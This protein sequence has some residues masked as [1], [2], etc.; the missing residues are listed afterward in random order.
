M[1]RHLRSTKTMAHTEFVSQWNERDLPD[2]QKQAE[3]D[4]HRAKIEDAKKAVDQ[5]IAETGKKESELS[6]EQLKP[7]KEARKKIEEL[8]KA[9]PQLPKVMAVAE[10]PVKTVPIHIRGNHLQLGPEPVARAIP[11]VFTST[12]SSPTFPADRSG[13]LEFARWLTSGQHP[14][15]T[16]LLVNRWWQGHFGEGLVRSPGNF[17]LTGEEPTHPEL[18]DYLASQF[19]ADQWSMKQLHRRLLLSAVYRRSSVPAKAEVPANS[20]VP[21][22]PGEPANSEVLADSGTSRPNDLENRYWAR[23]NRKRLE[24]EPLRDAILAMGENLDTRMGGQAEAV[25]GNFETSSTARGVEGSLRRTIYLPV[26]RAALSELLSTFDYVDSATSVAKRN[27][28]VVPHQSLF[29]MNN[30]LVIEQA[31]LL[32]KR[33]QAAADNDRQRIDW[34]VRAALGRPADDTELVAA[35]AFLQTQSK[36]ADAKLDR[37]WQRLCLS[38]LCTNEF[39][40]ID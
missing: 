25:Y 16:R 36:A 22:N 26:N 38:L 14:L 17:G 27:S 31:W 12:T 13:R 33:A 2:A 39:M 7:I 9:L 8:E 28:T 35:E 34:A 37:A 18:L 30:P 32:G 20:N 1:S 3:I 15:V 40:T 10:A 24:I 4:A 6:E 19:V 11:T 21:A 23:Q 29:L 5:Q